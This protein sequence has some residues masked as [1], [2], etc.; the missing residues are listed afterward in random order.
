ME[1][2]ELAKPL[3]AVD[4]I[5]VQF[6]EFA[7]QALSP[8]LRPRGDDTGRDDRR[9]HPQRRNRCQERMD[10]RK[11]D[12]RT[13]PDGDGDRCIDSKVGEKIVQRVDV[14][15]RGRRELS[16]A[17]A[18]QFP[19][20]APLDT[21]VELHAQQRLIAEGKDV[22]EPLRHPRS[23]ARTDDGDAEEDQR[24]EQAGGVRSACCKADKPT[25]RSTSNDGKSVLGDAADDRNRIAPATG[26]N[27]LQR[28]Q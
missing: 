10:D 22:P 3:N 21:V 7:A 8:D 27:A 12:D 6:A 19:R 5:G 20:S 23:E 2:E 15:K 16:G 25:T 14:G 26:M 18:E 4:R 1:D 24:R 28:F 13:D 17:A 9:E 11:R